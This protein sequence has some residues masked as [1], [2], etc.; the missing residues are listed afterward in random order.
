MDIRSTLSRKLAA[1]R[2]Y[3]TQ[4]PANFF[5]LQV[6]EEVLGEEFFTLAATSEAGPPP[7]RD[8]FEGLSAGG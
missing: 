1:F 4:V 3:E 2:C 8:L 5:Y 7:E 6:S